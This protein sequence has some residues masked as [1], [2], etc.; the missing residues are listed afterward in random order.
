[1]KD[2]WSAVA[3][4]FE[5]AWGK[6]ARESRLSGGPGVIALGFIMDAIIDRHRHRGIPSR[7]QFR[8]DLT[9]L[10]SVCRW[11]T[12]TWDFGPGRQRK[13]NELQNTPKDVRLLSD[14]LTLKYKALV[15]NCPKED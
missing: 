10:R 15:W 1:L 2:Y 6:P 8:V 11:T 12:G 9:P 14:Y 7:E 5:D 3:S 4:V 13:W